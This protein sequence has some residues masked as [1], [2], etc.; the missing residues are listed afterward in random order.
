MALCT[1]CGHPHGWFDGL[2]RPCAIEAGVP[3][4]PAPA[5]EGEAMPDPDVE[6]VVTEAPAT[7]PKP[8]E[9]PRKRRSKQ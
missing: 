4:V 1:N 6:T 8:A 3:L 7:E 2:C 5:V 9:A